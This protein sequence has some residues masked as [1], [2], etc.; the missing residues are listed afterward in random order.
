MPIRT[1]PTS[2]DAVSRYEP[3]EIDGRWAIYDTAEDRVSG[4]FG[5]GED[6]RRGAAAH[7]LQMN[8]A[9]SRDDGEGPMSL[10]AAIARHE[11][12]SEKPKPP[13]S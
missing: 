12:M 2:E 11:A 4:W 1:G 8:E 9:L 13:Q 5:K 3:R 6:E 10:H 7:A